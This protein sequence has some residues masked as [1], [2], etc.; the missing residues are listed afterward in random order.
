MAN[1]FDYTGI[2]T[3]RYAVVQMDPV[4]SN[5]NGGVVVAI[6]ESWPANTSDMIDPDTNETMTVFNLSN[7]FGTDH[8]FKLIPCG[9]DVEVNWIYTDKTNIFADSNVSNN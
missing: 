2:T 9:D 6:K 7:E 1:S 3:K 5:S 8:T 4:S